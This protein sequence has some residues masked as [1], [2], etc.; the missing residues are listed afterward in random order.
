MRSRSIVG[1]LSFLQVLTVVF[2]V[3]KAADLIDWSWWVVFA[4][5]W[6][7]PAIVVSIVIMLFAAGFVVAWLRRPR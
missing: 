3:L 7:P 5:L 2:I 4:P 6:G 1:G